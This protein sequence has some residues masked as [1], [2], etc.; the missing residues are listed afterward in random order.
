MS[1]SENEQVNVEWKAFVMKERTL[2]YQQDK[3]G[4]KSREMR[5]SSD[6]L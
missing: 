1:E 3:G 5:N 4:V 6:A 2:A